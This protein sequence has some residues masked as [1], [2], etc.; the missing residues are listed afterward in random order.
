MCVFAK[1]IEKYLSRQLFF[2]EIFVFLLYFLTY[3]FY[4]L[5]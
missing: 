2:Y 4:E 3:R 1:F 5:C